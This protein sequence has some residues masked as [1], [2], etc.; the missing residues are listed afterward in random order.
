MLIDDAIG[1]Q[2]LS[3]EDISLTN[4]QFGLAQRGDMSAG[5]GD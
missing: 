3:S 2:S 5:S 4:L 1:H